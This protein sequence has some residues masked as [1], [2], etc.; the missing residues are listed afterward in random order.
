MENHTLEVLIKL[1]KDLIKNELKHY[2]ISMGTNKIDIN[3]HIIDDF[4]MGAI[5]TGYLIDKNKTVVKNTP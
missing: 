4:I 5:T 1:K 2:L 3:D